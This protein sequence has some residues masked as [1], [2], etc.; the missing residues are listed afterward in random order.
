MHQIEVQGARVH[1]LKNV[2]AIIPKNKLVVVTGVSGSGKSSFIF[3]TLHQESQHLYLRATGLSHNFSQMDSFDFICGLSPTIAVK[4]RMVGNINPRSVVGTSTRLLNL[5][6]LVFANEWVAPEAE[7]NDLGAFA[8]G[9][10]LFNSPHGQCP[11]CHGRGYVSQVNWEKIFPD[12]NAS[13]EELHRFAYLYPKKKFEEK[14]YIEKRLV[15]FAERFGVTASTRFS[16]LSS[17][18]KEVF[19]TH[20]PQRSRSKSH[21]Q[22][23]FYGIQSVMEERL[24]DKRSKFRTCKRRSNAPPVR[25]LASMN[26]RCESGCMGITSV[27]W[28]G[29]KLQNCRRS[30]GSF[31]ITEKS[32]M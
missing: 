16:D 15:N 25:G 20:R 9:M 29:W 6:A 26:E 30:S 27:S 4:Q 18:A 19:L 22:L 2:S 21:P 24:K 12:K 5:L 32:V 1:N 8:P 17:E 3:D 7:H 28:A 13:I 23:I 10:F 31:R 11:E 14:A